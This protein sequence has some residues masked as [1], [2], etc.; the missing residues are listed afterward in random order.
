MVP[1]INANSKV[2]RCCC[3]AISLLIAA[4][5]G[6]AAL[7]PSTALA[8]YGRQSWAMENGLPQNTV[9]ALLQTR[10][11]FVWLGTE[12]GLVRFDGNGFQ[13]FDRT[14]TPALP[15]NDIHALL[16]TRDGALWVGTS[17]GLAR[18]KDG[19][20]K[21]F[22]TTDGLPGSDVRA[23]AED[24][25]GA[26][27]AYTEG[28]LAR[29][30]GERFEATGD[31]RP[32]AVITTVT[33]SGQT[34]SWVDADL[35][36][37]NAWRQAAAQAGLPKED[38]EFLA[39]FNTGAIGVANKNT[40][41][42]GSLN[43]LKTRLSVGHEL[44]GSRIQALLADHEGCLWIGTNGGLA[45]WSGGKLERL[46]VTDPLASASVLAMMEDREGNLWVGTETGGLHILRDQRFKA[47]TARD[48]LSSDNTTAVVED[49]T[50]A[51]WVGTGGG[52]LNVVRTGEA[53]KTVI[54]GYSVRERAAE[55]RDPVAGRGAQ[56][57]HVGGHCRTG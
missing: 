5:P 29:L 15:G 49:R 4:C 50:G 46:P 20:D 18:W 1:R 38:L 28:G 24:P 21:T 13:V 32:G 7:E 43:G 6:A 23:L 39:E 25:S 9:Q 45:R 11:G 54:S 44:P 3:L 16:E 10:D 17:E 56:R 48:G 22:T 2:P 30:N 27:W 19:A 26:M 33:G 53:G 47:L 34:R 14:S 8:N 51:L 36:A 41:M 55:R 12:V 37:G 42:L 52:G 57:R 40:L 35:N 31:W